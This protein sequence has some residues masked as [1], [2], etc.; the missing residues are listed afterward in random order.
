MNQNLGDTFR[1][2][3]VEIHVDAEECRDARHV[4][5]LPQRPVV[6]TIRI[7]RSPPVQVAGVACL[8]FLLYAGHAGL[9]KR[10]HNG[11]PFPSGLCSQL[12]VGNPISIRL[13]KQKKMQKHS[14]KE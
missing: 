13:V 3:R 4:D 12:S 8:W 10:Q 14:L 6:G 9:G 2:E 5:A 1:L 11:R 7:I